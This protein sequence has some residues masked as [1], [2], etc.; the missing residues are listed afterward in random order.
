VI[1]QA[2]SAAP[3][4]DPRVEQD[5][6]REFMDRD[7]KA[8]MQYAADQRI[9]PMLDEM[10]ANTLQLTAQREEMQGAERLARHEDP[11]T[12]E[13][14]KAYAPEVTQ[15]LAAMPLDVRAQPGVVE[16]AFTHVKA[17]HQDE[18]VERRV[19]AALARH[20]NGGLEPPTQGRAAVSSTVPLTADQRRFIEAAD[21]TEAEYRKYQIEPWGQG[22]RP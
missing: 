12:R 16:S 22:S 8:A 5:Q 17:A 10:Q 2:A 3:V 15:F 9:K 6:F 14:W 19:K 7:P 20:Q 21:M 13:E 1:Q 4:A 11:L 18:V